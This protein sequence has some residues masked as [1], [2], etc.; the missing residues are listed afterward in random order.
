MIARKKEMC[1]VRSNNTERCS[2]QDISYIMHP[3]K[4]SCD[5]DE[6]CREKEPHSEAF[7]A[8]I[9]GRRK[10][11]E[12]RR[13]AWCGCKQTGTPSFCDGTHSRLK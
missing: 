7:V 6:E 8:Q 4:Y 9:H 1:T 5:A 12:K 3:R 13:V 10:R 2:A 11:E